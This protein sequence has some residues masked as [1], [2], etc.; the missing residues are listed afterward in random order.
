LHTILTF[1]SHIE[2]VSGKLVD[3]KVSLWAIGTATL[4]FR[5][6]FRTVVAGT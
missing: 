2:D 5:V 3:V 4:L 1:E 6:G